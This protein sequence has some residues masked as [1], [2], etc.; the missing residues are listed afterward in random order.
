MYGDVPPEPEAVT[1]PSQVPEHV[2]LMGEIDTVGGAFTVTVVE[3]ETT[4]AGV[5]QSVTVKETVLVPA[6]PYVTPL[7]GSVEPEA[8]VPPPVFHERVGD[9]PMMQLVVPV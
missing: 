2:G 3:Q 6:V 5:L 7:S 9:D 4:Q 8:G 1:A